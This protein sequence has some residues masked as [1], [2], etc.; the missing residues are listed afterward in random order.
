MNEDGTNTN[1]MNEDDM[2]AMFD[3]VSHS[4]RVMRDAADPSTLIHAQTSPRAEA[5]VLE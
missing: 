1:S 4:L 3:A 2:R 5:L